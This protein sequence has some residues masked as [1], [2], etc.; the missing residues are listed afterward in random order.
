M[1]R[2]RLNYSGLSVSITRLPLNPEIWGKSALNAL[3]DMTAQTEPVNRPS[4]KMT[5]A[6]LDELIRAA[7]EAHENDLKIIEALRPHCIERRLTRA[8][9]AERVGSLNRKK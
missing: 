8:E 7:N 1:T 2:K 4:R 6:E 5:V 9:N 3:G